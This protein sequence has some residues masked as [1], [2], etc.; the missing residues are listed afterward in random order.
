M[1]DKPVHRSQ[2]S[3][4]IYL[5][6]T[7]HPHVQT[8]SI[9]DRVFLFSYFHL[10]PPQNGESPSFSSTSFWQNQPI[11]NHIDVVRGVRDHI[12]TAM[13]GTEEL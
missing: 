7:F 5:S 10:F 3:Q 11:V 4:L 6:L 8:N 12:H 13:P 1:K 2:H 9:Y